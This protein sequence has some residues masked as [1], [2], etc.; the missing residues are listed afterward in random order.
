MKSTWQFLLILVTLVTSMAVKAQS[1][2]MD[3]KVLLLAPMD[4]EIEFGN[5][6]TAKRVLRGFDIPF[7]VVAMLDK[8]GNPLNHGRSLNLVHP[9]GRGKYY[10][11]I[12]TNQMLSYK[13]HSTM[14]SAQ[15][16]EL[17]DYEA[18]YKARQV[19]LYS[20]PSMITGVEPVVEGNDRPNSVVLD[21]NFAQLD[22]SLST[23][24]QIPIK[25]NWHYPVKIVASGINPIAYFTQYIPGTMNR[26]VAGVTFS[27]TDGR[28]QLHLFYGQ[29]PEAA[30][31]YALG[32]AWV[33]WMTRGLY[34]GQRRVY[35]NVHIDDLFLPSDIKY[36]KGLPGSSPI[37]RM[38]AFDLETFAAKRT[39]DLFP[40]TRNKN[41]R[42]EY[43]FNG[44]G[45]I[46]KG[47]YKK[48]P[49]FLAAKK[50]ISDFYWVSHTYTHHD[51][52][53][54]SYKLADWE[55][56]NNLVVSRALLG[57]NTKYFSPHS[58]VTP[59]ISGL[60]NGNALKAMK[61]NGIRHIVNDMSVE[62]QRPPYVHT[63]YYSSARV[64]GESGVL[65]MPRFPTEIY[66]QASLPQELT[67]MFDGIHNDLLSRKVHSLQD[68]YNFETN[69]TVFRLLNYQEAA[70]MFHQANMR[71]FRAG[72]GYE[73][74]VSLW[75]KNVLSG[76]RQYSNLPVLSLKMDDWSQVYLKKMER[77]RCDGG[78]RVLVQDGMIIGVQQWANGTCNLS[79]TLVG[80]DFKDAPSNV[81]QYGPDKTI[82]KRYQASSETYYLQK[83]VSL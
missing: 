78:S 36:V 43:A 60:F 9:D 55:L 33:H 57:K 47:G 73:S 20:E 79:L 77:E 61:A 66:Y 71:A 46:E 53:K 80:N 22:P 7:D 63:A 4:D 59:H 10:A 42:I 64:N 15:W 45:V 6:A 14:T 51:L 67:K 52:N 72:N 81:V 3:M 74:L 16:D 44:A 18:R 2:S 83:A 56:K 39:Q 13:E 12:L 82:E 54:I 75:I 38:S 29:T 69:A 30:G 41:Y 65:I 5:L 70:Y 26:A 21:S 28:D 37:Y 19:S 17:K 34:M 32:S 1:Y 76:L 68:V 24:F 25:D 40:F 31:A 11:V 23:N 50:H 48:D 35:L 27:T 58:M 62:K 8:K 49:L